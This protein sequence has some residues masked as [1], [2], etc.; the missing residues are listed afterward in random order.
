MGN[1]I[2]I[3]YTNAVY[4]NAFVTGNYYTG[5]GVELADADDDSSAAVM[6]PRRGFA[7]AMLCSENQ[8][9]EYPL[10]PP[11]YAGG[12]IAVL[13]VF[14]L[15]TLEPV[16]YDNNTISAS[17]GSSVDLGLAFGDAVLIRDTT[18]NDAELEGW[19]VV[20]STDPGEWVLTRMTGL[21]FGVGVETGVLTT[22]TAGMFNYRVSPSSRIG[23]E[24]GLNLNSEPK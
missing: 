7:S 15:N 5:T 12:D 2:E 20:T 16:D 11:V 3:R 21:E 4:P 22:V 9:G 1:Q 13:E 24:F 14:D 10:T 18:G 17:E 19:Y 8:P 6:G 23:S